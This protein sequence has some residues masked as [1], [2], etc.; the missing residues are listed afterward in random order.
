MPK[1]GFVAFNEL[2]QKI[3]FGETVALKELLDVN[4]LRLTKSYLDTNVSYYVIK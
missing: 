1:G 2:N 4:K 3:F